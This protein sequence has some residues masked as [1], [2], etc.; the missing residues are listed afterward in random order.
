[1]MVPTSYRVRLVFRARYLARPTDRLH[2]EREGKYPSDGAVVDHQ[3]AGWLAGSRKLMPDRI[4]A[5][6]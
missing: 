5:V 2:F 1:M 4:Y 6:L 3:L